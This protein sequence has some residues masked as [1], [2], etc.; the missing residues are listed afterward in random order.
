M[1]QIKLEGSKDYPEKESDAKTYT[2]LL[3]WL[4]TAKTDINVATRGP[5]GES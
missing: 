1:R 4:Y 5:K 2:K 3:K